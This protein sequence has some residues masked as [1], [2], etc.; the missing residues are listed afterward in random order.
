MRK[1]FI[2][3]LFLCVTA[4]FATAAVDTTVQVD[5]KMVSAL[6][7]NVFGAAVM[8]TVIGLLLFMFFKLPGL[9]EKVINKKDAGM[10]EKLDGIQTDIAE[11]RK[12]D[13]EQDK[14]IRGISLDMLKKTIHDERIPM[15]ERMSAA[16]RYLRRGGNG[17]TRK[18]VEEVIIPTNPELYASLEKL[19]EEV[20][21]T[22]PNGLVGQAV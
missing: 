18:Y 1:I 5:D 20:A 2:F 21:M 15:E 14:L 6:L 3:L 19:I 13:A 8:I 7:N 9:L 4:V 11:I 12:H 22:G 10:H 17:V 16:V